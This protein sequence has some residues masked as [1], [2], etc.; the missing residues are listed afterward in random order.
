MLIDKYSLDLACARARALVVES[1]EV[2]LCNYFHGKGDQARA[3]VAMENAVDAMYKAQELTEE[4]WFEEETAREREG[5]RSELAD[6]SRLSDDNVWMAETA[7]QDCEDPYAEPSC[8]YSS[9][10]LDDGLPF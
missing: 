2:E 3:L 4:L 7:D 1:I 9:A 10:G 6:W 5:L 8:L